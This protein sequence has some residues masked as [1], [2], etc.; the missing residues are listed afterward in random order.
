MKQLQSI[1]EMIDGLPNLA[2][3][4]QTAMGRVVEGESLHQ[5]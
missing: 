1:P 3:A 4:D 2:E 5:D